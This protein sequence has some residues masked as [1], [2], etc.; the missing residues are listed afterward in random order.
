MLITISNE[1]YLELH[2]KIR[3]LEE[4]NEEMCKMMETHHH[5]SFLE[6]EMMKDRIREQDSYI[7]YLSDWRRKTATCQ[8]CY[9]EGFE[10]GKR[11]ERNELAYILWMGGEEG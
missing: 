6:N 4:A 10:D 2:Q 8:D 9:K 7:K 11:Y 5:E 1:E 3:E